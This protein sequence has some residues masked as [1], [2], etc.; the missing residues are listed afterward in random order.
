MCGKALPA[1][2]TLIRRARAAAGLTQ[3][4][5]A[6]RA[7]VSGRTISDLER[8]AVR[9]PRRDTLELL[10]N[11][12]DL[13]P[14]ERAEWQR[15]QRRLATRADRSVTTRR[16]GLPVS[17]TS[18]VG[19]T[20]EVSDIA[21][22]LRRAGT[23]LVT[24]T[25]VGGVGKTRLALAV[26]ESLRDDY[27]AGAWFVDLTPVSDPALMLPTIAATLDLPGKPGQPL[28][29]TLVGFLGDKPILLVLD[30]F[31][32]IVDAAE[33]VSDLLSACQLLTILVTSRVPLRIQGEQLYPAPPLSLLPPAEPLDTTG[34]ERSDA[35]ALFVQCAQAIKP[36]FTLNADNAQVVYEICQRLDRLP[37]AIE[38]TAA[39]AGILSPR[40]LRDRLDRRLPLLTGGPRNA[41]AHQRT[42]RDTLA[43]SFELL[44]EEQQMLFRRLSVF[45]GG[46]SLEAAGT[47][48]ATKG[49]GELDLLNELRA[50][51]DHSLIRQIEQADG[52]ARFDMLETVREFGQEQLARNGEA[53]LIRQRYAKYYVELSEQASENFDSP[54]EV[55]WLKLLE[56]EQD[57]LHAA[58]DCWR[59]QGQIEQGLNLVAALMRFWLNGGALAAGRVQIT[60]FLRLAGPLRTASRAR[61]LIAAAWLFSWQG[62]YPEA[63]QMS[64]EGLSIWQELGNRDE[65]PFALV[66]LGVVTGLAGDD[67][68][69]VSAFEQTMPVAREV[70][71]AVNLSR[72]LNNLGVLALT[73]TGDGREVVL[74]RE[75][76]SVARAVGSPSLIALAAANL[77]ASTQKQG[78]VLQAEELFREALALALETDTQWQ[79]AAFLESLAKNALIQGRAIRAAR[80][81]G[82]AQ[83][84]RE[85]IG[86]PVQTLDRAEHE[87]YIRELQATL[88]EQFEHIRIA[89]AALSMDE[90][91]AEALA[92]GDGG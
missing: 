57:N 27:P 24:L 43:W 29:R 91:V 19:R 46:C 73:A 9:A 14:G 79:I 90:A 74:L 59:E 35:V 85:R 25:G 60:S 56:R 75:A 8:G 53:D 4:A 84:I 58:L 20:R 39:W 62:D 40:A 66:T 47:V 16:Q 15:L 32:Q 64:E 36:D 67:E 44:T 80:L 12:L 52:E 30:N 61:G 34:L 50:L 86:V 6:E 31:E 3:E 88:G 81:I 72:A 76:V 23:R 48:V 13:D 45:R 54:E 71:D 92:G 51:V 26:A 63:V 11:A 41:P 38:L 70:G 17:L 10:A 83:A 77:G 5:L 68:R 28:L 65:L 37:L 42:M 55:F 1:F 22:L 49:R 2:H 33:D 82:A 87:R 7:G 69:A 21:A 18:F 78:D 89:G